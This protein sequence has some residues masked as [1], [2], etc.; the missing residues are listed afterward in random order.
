MLSY[1]SFEH[2]LRRPTLRVLASVASLRFQARPRVV[3]QTKRMK[4][5]IKPARISIQFWPSKP[6]K[7]NCPIRNCTVS[8]PV[9]GQSKRC[10]D[11]NILF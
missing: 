10:G 1:L 3:V 9:F 6:R 11:R 5:A 7:V 4:A 8:V 2:D